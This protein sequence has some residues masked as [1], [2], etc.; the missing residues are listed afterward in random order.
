MG[1]MNGL[2]FVHRWWMPFVVLAVASAGSI[3]WAWYEQ[4]GMAT[5]TGPEIGA[6]YGTEWALRD[7]YLATVVPYL[8]GVVAGVWLIDGDGTTRWAALW[9][10]LAAIARI[11]APL[12]VVTSPQDV[13]SLT[14]QHYIDWQTLQPLLWFADVQMALLGVTVWAI[15]GHFA[16]AERGFRGHHEPAY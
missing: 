1:A 16:G 9:A 12:W 3:A 7:D 11:A 15:F 4:A 2:E 8:F 10:L 6:A 14:G 13:V 5:V